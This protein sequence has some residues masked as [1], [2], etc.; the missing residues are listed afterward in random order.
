MEDSN[1]EAQ[2]GSF[3]A[4]QCNCGALERWD[5]PVPM[6]PAK[7]HGRLLMYVRISSG[8]V[9]FQSP[10]M[11]V[12]PMNVVKP[13][14]PLNLHMEIT[15]DGNLNISWY[16]PIL[17]P[18]PLQYQ[19]RY[20][21]NST[22]V[23]KE[24]DKI[25]SVA[26]LLV[27]H[28]LP[29][30]SY[31]AQVRAKSMAGLG[32][33]GDWSTPQVLTTPAVMY[34]PPKLLTSAGSKVSFRCMYKNGMEMVPAN[35]IVWWVNLAAAVPPSQYE[36][37]SDHVS[38]VTFPSVRATR[39]R[40][41]FT[42]DALYC[43][44]THECH[45]HYAELYAID[46]NI[47][48]SCETD[49]YLTKMTCRWSTNTIQSLVGITSQLRYHRSRL[50][51]SDPPRIHPESEPKDCHLQR[52]GFYE[53]V[54]HPIFLFSGYTMWIRISHP[55]GSLNSPP[56]C[57]LPNSVAKPLP[58]SSV[59]AEITPNVGLLKIT[60]EKPIFPENHLRYQIR[61]GLRGR[62]GQRQV[63]EVYGGK[64]TSASIPVRDP[65]AVYA[66][67]VRCR[68]LDGLGYW[69]NWS[70]PAYTVVR[71]VRAPVRGPEVWRIMNGD[72]TKGQ[73]NVTLL[74]KPLRRNES[75]CSVQR[76]VVSH[77]AP[78]KG[79]WAE[80]AGSRT[81]LTFPVAEQEHTV[82][83]LALNS[84]GA[85]SA[86]SNLSFSGAM[87][88]VTVVQA[89]SA[90]PL[91]SSCMVLSWMLVQGERRPTHLIVE[92]K[93]L[94]EHS[95][96]KWLRLPPDVRKYYIRDHFIPI[97]KYQLSLY[98]VFAE[99]VGKPEIINSFTQGDI[100]NAMRSGAGLYV[101][102]PV[103]ISFSVLLLGT[104][105]ISRQRMKKLFWE[106]VP[107]PK[108]CSWAQGLNF[109]KPETFE[110]LFT[111]HTCG[112]LLLEPETISEDISVDTS[113][114]LKDDPAP[115]AT[116]SLLGTAPELEK[117][118]VWVSPCSS[119]AHCSQAWEDK[120]QRPP[121]VKYAM[122]VSYS[123]SSDMEEDPGL[124]RSSVAM[125]FSSETSPQGDSFSSSSW[126]VEGQA[127]LLLPDQQC[128]VQCPPQSFMGGLD[129]D[130]LLETEGNFP[131]ENHSERSVYYLG[132]TSIKK[133]ESGVFLTEESGI[134]C[135]FPAH[136]VFS[137][138]RLLQDSCSHFV[139][140]NFNV[141]P[142]GKKASVP[143]VPQFQTCA[144]QTRK[145][146]ENK[147]CDLTV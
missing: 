89:L 123:K 58:P 39:P 20:S 1:L 125:C 107:N 25:V 93:N 3:Q 48:I 87:S 105:L 26:A 113:W 126:E 23:T 102:V 6:P 112:P 24:V 53:C 101:V 135:P 146:M 30:A 40:G 91:N 116:V 127:C 83:V 42:Y 41:S 21:E 114:K 36:V 84:I 60:W 51:C 22:T 63:H 65:C 75:L 16:N 70:S 13:D 110:H 49:G 115:A 37:V 56:T 9:T 77:W 81:S 31:K 131:E 104:L 136:C 50:Y 28:V 79:A 76:Y 82:T 128:P 143:Y 134:L 43:C 69:S 19:V 32:I 27:D 96:M 117:G 44:T 10:V 139:E 108:N 144:T 130:A 109:H 106:D 100:E 121:S 45:R 46:V 18:F 8:E 47:N 12:Q 72:A 142:S 80:D 67:Q 137:D 86:N 140:N 35:K 94:H 66:A 95:G 90:Y 129:A 55:L 78:R 61:Y 133:R 124:P 73:R 5:C 120:S 54:F 98:P 71:D 111:K 92:W 62:E 14:P 122:L 68:R 132:V 85:S 7:L 74:W 59:K 145:F 38:Q 97:E 15:E 2:K 138:L 17:V 64:P 34:F 29:G 99:G 57:V 4:V 88:K 52:D 11:S 118:S 33:W 147:L 103:V 141:G 119:S